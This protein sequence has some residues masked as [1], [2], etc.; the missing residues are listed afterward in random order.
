MVGESGFNASHFATNG[1]E[2]APG[3]WSDDD[4]TLIHHIRNALPELAAWG[5]L[6]IGTAWG[7]YSQDVWLLS[8]LEE[9]LHSLNRERLMPFLAYIHYHETHGEPPSWGIPI[10]DLDA[11]VVEHRLNTAV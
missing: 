4:R 1:H 11:Y 7:S 10:E 3:E 6:P 8:W 5:D 2:N 9:E